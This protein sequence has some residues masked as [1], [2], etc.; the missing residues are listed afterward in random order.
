MAQDE[1]ELVRSA[2]A[3]WNAGDLETALE[4]AHAEIEVAQD[5]QIPGAVAVTGKEE[6]KRWLESFYETWESFDIS[7]TEIRR[8]GDRIV[9]ISHVNARS[10]TMSV[11]VQTDTA[12][13]LTM[14]NGQAVRWESYTDPAVALGALE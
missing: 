6:F 7:P 10:K 8:A 1:I 9:V 11:P 3:A 4:I 13:V 2:Y 5:P 14:R 12:H